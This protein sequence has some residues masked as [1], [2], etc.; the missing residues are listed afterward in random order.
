MNEVKEKNTK[1][2]ISPYGGRETPEG[3]PCSLSC[4]EVLCVLSAV[5]YMVLIDQG[6][7]IWWV[8]EKL[9]SNGKCTSCVQ[10]IRALTRCNVIDERLAVH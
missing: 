2:A 7:A 3:S 9:F 6:V 1:A 8:P 4:C 5:S 10:H